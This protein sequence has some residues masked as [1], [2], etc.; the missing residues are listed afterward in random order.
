MKWLAKK[1]K[2]AGA[3]TVC[4]ECAPSRDKRGAWEDFKTAFHDFNLMDKM[5]DA[6]LLLGF[7]LALIGLS[8][9]VLVGVAPTTYSVLNSDAIGVLQKLW[10]LFLCGIAGVYLSKEII[11]EAIRRP[12]VRPYA[13]TFS[14]LAVAYVGYK[15]LF[16][17]L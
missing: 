13:L 6:T 15:L 3:E 8:L 17:G 12:S 4:R 5:T 14:A 2:Y 1:T 11:I 7:R 10:N 9:M 16:W